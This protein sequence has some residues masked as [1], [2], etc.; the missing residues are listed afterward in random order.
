MDAEIAKYKREY[1]NLDAL[2][3]E[4][5]LNMSEDDHLKF[6]ASLASGETAEAPK[7]L[8][9]ED[10]IQVINSAADDAQTDV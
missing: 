5:I 8:I 6:Q 1:H 7:K 4:A 2:M 9:L 10:A 3:I